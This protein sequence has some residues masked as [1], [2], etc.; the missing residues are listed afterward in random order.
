M[1]CPELKWALILEDDACLKPGATA[2]MAREAF[3]DGM[4]ILSE[5]HPE[6]GVVYL[7]GVLSTFSKHKLDVQPVHGGLRAASQV[8]QTHAFLVKSE[9]AP[10]ILDLLSKGY[11]VDAAYVSWSRRKCNAMRTF[12]FEPQLLVQPGGAGR[13]K[14]SD[15]FI[16]GEFFKQESSRLRKCD[17]KFTAKR[18]RRP[19][20]MIIAREA[21]PA[22]ASE[23]ELAEKP[24]EGG[25]SQDSGVFVDQECCDTDS[26]EV[27]SLT[28]NLNSTDTTFFPRG[29][30]GRV[31]HPRAST[32]LSSGDMNAGDLRQNSHP[33][34]R[35][36]ALFSESAKQLLVAKAAAVAKTAARPVGLLAMISARKAFTERLPPT[37]LRVRAQLVGRRLQESDIFVDEECSM[38]ESVEASG[39]NDANSTSKPTEVSCRAAARY[40]FPGAPFRDIASVRPLQESL[41]KE[42]GPAICSE[43]AK[44]LLVPKAA[45]VA[46]TRAIPVGLL[47]KISARRAGLG[48]FLSQ[49]IVRPPIKKCRL[50]EEF[51]ASSAK[52]APNQV[53]TACRAGL[54]AAPS[55]LRDV[56]NMHGTWLL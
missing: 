56:T 16:D 41:G 1:A 8:Y 49:D 39:F 2:C 4:R 48:S 29:T 52:F 5:K 7:G 3:D 6:W 30:V 15:I 46:K 18:V 37:A 25:C 20:R 34:E 10:E 32:A 14:D 27:A 26:A 55:A 36:P 12:L 51:A 21:L 40:V 33:I 47:A 50:S 23:D 31:V 44:K 11:A 24:L 53:G 9:L 35:R 45:A 54:P 38:E 28:S 43:K 17:Y 22:T 13:W 42:N 19:T